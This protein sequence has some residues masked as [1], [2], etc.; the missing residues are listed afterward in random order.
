MLEDDKKQPE[1]RSHD[2]NEEV[3]RIV[4]RLIALLQ[5]ASTTKGMGDTTFMEQ[6]RA[7]ADQL[8]GTLGDSAVDLAYAMLES[9]RQEEQAFIAQKLISAASQQGL[10]EQAKAAG[11][12]EQTVTKLQEMVQQNVRTALEQQLPELSGQLAEAKVAPDAE[13]AAEDARAQEKRKEF[14]VLGGHTDQVAQERERQATATK[15]VA[16]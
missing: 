5:A 3:T 16:I 12:D 15:P 10:V 1:G 9:D 11:V 14:K 8:R 4:Q 6:A 13:K 2:H 7:E